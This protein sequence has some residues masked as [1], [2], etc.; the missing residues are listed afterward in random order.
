MVPFTWSFNAAHHWLEV[1][2]RLR[3]AAETEQLKFA[4]T[5]I[6]AIFRDE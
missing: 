3:I 1:P 5:A 4:V 2:L 6:D